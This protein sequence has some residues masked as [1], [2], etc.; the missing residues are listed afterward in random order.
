MQPARSAVRHP[1][2]EQSWHT[3]W[4]QAWLGPHWTPHVPQ[5]FGS[6]ATAVQTPL[7]TPCPVG[8]TQAPATQTFPPLQAA[9]QAPQFLLSFWVATQ[10]SP[11]CTVPLTHCS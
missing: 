9:P 1:P 3:P 10:V 2:D 11:H 8:H 5:L 7:H 4:L 6:V